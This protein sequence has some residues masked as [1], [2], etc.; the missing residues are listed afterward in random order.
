MPPSSARQALPLVLVNGAVIDGVIEIEAQSN[1]F[2]GADRFSACFALSATGSGL[3]SGP[4]LLVEIRISLDGE[5]ASLVTGM[6]DTVSID[7]IRGEVRVSG[8]DLTSLF[9]AAQ[10]E[11]SF[12]NQTSSD[13]ANLLAG[14]R[15][16][17]ASIQPTTTLI[18][19]YY[20]TSRTRTALPQHARATTEW[21][22]LCWIAQ[23]ENFDV[24]VSG[25]T[26]NFQPAGQAAPSLVLSPGDCISLNMHHALDIA[27]GV[28]ITVKSW[29]SLSQNAIVQTS[30][31]TDDSGATSSRTIIRP[32][33]SSDDAQILAD[34][35]VSQISGHERNLIIEVPGELVTVPRM[36]MALVNTGTD[37]DGQY[38]VCG[39][40]RRLT[41]AHG[42]TQTIEARSVPWTP[43]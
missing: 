24:W 12:E 36:I 5:W 4:S 35:L 20:Q 17:G 43:S 28:T 34:R 23:L 29:D 40:E 25:Q 27:A 3:W 8:R 30:S 21:D 10:I 41:F 6:V 33:L 37:F 18:G 13:I 38:V 2:F 14:R 19:R 42:F 22:L 31:N 1:S 39:V 11:E 32:N 15:G 26:L 16:L 7:P 9:V